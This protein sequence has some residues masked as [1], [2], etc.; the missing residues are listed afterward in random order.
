MNEREKNAGKEMKKKRKVESTGLPSSGNQIGI[1]PFQATLAELD[2]GI[3]PTDC[4][5]TRQSTT[6]YGI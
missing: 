2:G 4:P 5:H 1:S 6:M 3:S